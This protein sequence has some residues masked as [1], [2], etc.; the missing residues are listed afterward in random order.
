M[1]TGTPRGEGTA[2]GQEAASVATPRRLI[3][4]RPAGPG[5]ASI[6]AL[7]VIILSV[8]PST[9]FSCNRREKQKKPRGPGFVKRAGLE[10]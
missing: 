6:P 3:A 1:T 5:R 10:A 8:S 2:W 7:S 9:W 4:Q